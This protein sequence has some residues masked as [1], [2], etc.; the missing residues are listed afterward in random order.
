MA[1]YEVKGPTITSV[2]DWIDESLGAG[3]FHRLATELDADYPERILPGDWYPVRPMVRAL[4]QAAERQGEDFEALCERLS[5]ET[6][7]RDLNGIYR[8]FLWAASPRMFLRMVPR[9]WAGYARFGEVGELE[10]QD[11]H[12]SVWITQIPEDLVPWLASSWKGFLPPAMDLAGAEDAVASVPERRK[13]E[14]DDSWE[15]HYELRYSS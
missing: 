11:G 3:S 4:E 6:A 10:N 1:D 15:I 8:A 9:I 13:S 5:A 2:R 7:I 12:F 14:G